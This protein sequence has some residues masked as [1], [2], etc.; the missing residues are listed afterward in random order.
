[1]LTILDTKVCN[2]SSWFGIFKNINEKYKVVDANNFDVKN[3]S[4]LIFPGIGNF[5]N[6]SDYVFK[7]KIDLKIKKLI[8]K[9]I[10]YLG[11]CMGMQILLEESDES[12]SSKGL[13]IIKGKV[14]KINSNK[15]SCPHNGW[16]NNKGQKKTKLFNNIKNIEDF[17]FNHS[18]YCDVEEKKII[19]RTLSDDKKIVTSFEKDSIY[20]VQFHPE[21]SHD[22]GIKILKN[23]ISI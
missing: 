20:G 21:K 18:F 11:V 9:K 12:K 13:G 15:I 23:F 8:S 2:L 5:N 14:R 17:Y 19:T 1:M 7:N 6:I 4:K 22:S 3:I 16:N 10:P